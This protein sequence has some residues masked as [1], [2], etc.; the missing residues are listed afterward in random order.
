[1][2]LTLTQGQIQLFSFLKKYLFIHFWLPWV[3]VAAPCSS[4]GEQGLLLIAVYSFL[5]WWFLLLAEYGL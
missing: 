5:L 1:M 4:C 2:Q 3:F